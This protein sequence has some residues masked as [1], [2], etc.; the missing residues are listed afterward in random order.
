MGNGYYKP[1]TPVSWDKPLTTGQVARVCH[2]APRTVSKW[3]DSGR[4][5][6]YRLPT[7]HD[8]GCDRRIYADSLYTFMLTYGLR[9]P[10]ELVPPR[11]VLVYGLAP[12]ECVPDG[13][14]CDNA[15][16]LGSLLATVTPAAAVV[17]DADGLQDA[18]AALSAV[19]ER[20]PHC[21]CVLVVG[22][23]VQPPAVEGVR[24]L[25]RPVAWDELA[26]SLA[27]GRVA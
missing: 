17:G 20:H 7:G 16:H 10:P 13:V 25:R 21:A 2:V 12:G 11:G 9:I 22:P 18:L 14:P 3:L 8:R 23:D 15:F 27:P 19:R 26:R 4:L 6:G 24:V 1:N 5:K